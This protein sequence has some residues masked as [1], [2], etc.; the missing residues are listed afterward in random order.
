MND[1]RDYGP[2]YDKDDEFKAAA[3]LHQSRFRVE[4]LG[5][6]DFADYGNRLTATDAAAGLNFYAAWPAIFEAAKQRFPLKGPT[7][8]K[9]YWDMLASDYIPFNFFVPLRE[10]PLLADALCSSWVGHPVQV[11]QICIEWAPSPK[12]HYL[13]DATSFDAYFEYLTPT[14]AHGGV[15]V[16]TKYTEKEYDWGT[17]ERI[18]MFD[19]NSMYHK[20][21]A[22]SG[23][24]ADGTVDFLR[25]KRFK[26][27]WRNHLLG[28]AMLLRDRATLATFT[29]V[30]LYPHGNTHFVEVA[31]EYAGLL[32]P[33]SG[34][35]RFVAQTHEDV[36]AFL[37]NR[38]STPKVKDWLDYLSRRFIVAGNRP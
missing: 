32:R 28:E 33:D 34:S 17:T 25:T 15:G 36:L 9:L 22:A 12:A 3:R 26:Q 21:H 6:P 19:E 1:R 5:L 4:Q 23:I 27:L 10:E 14:G 31:A 20:V 29:S 35:R 8:P 16:E 38:A 24:Y 18:R 30:L 37:R 13:D 11:T 7:V 2:Q